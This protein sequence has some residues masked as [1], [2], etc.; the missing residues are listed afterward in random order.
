MLRISDFFEYCRKGIDHTLLKPEG[1]TPEIMKLIGEARDN[2][3]ASVC[4]NPYWVSLCAGELRGSGVDICT[5]VGF[6]LGATT[7]ETKAAETREAIRNGA[8][9]IDM[10]LNVGALK[11]GNFSYNRQDIGG[12]VRAAEGRVVKVILETCLL[13]DQEIIKASLIAQ[14][15]GAAFVKTSTGFNKG[16]ATAAQVALMR[17]VVGRK[18]GV[19][20][21]GGVRSF[22]DA[23]TMLESG[24][25]R[26]GA[27]A[28]V[29]IVT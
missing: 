29:A 16:G 25:D 2:H 19:K 23:L 3:F 21:A 28:S 8:T 5:V 27:S 1:T 10:V 14:E 13:T 18:M 22:G 26:I 24:A 17:R 12:V 9:E 6:P 4:I 15:A 11:D 7:R 20:A